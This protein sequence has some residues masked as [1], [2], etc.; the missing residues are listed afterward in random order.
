MFLEHSPIIKAANIDEA[1]ED[2]FG[3]LTAEAGT[4]ES[5]ELRTGC[6]LPAVTDTQRDDDL[7]CR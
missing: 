1:W 6:T 4:A 3:T 5:R 2:W 7:G